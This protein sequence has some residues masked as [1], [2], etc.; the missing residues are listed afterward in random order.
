ME[1]SRYLG[2]GDKHLGFATLLIS[3]SDSTVSE[4]W[5]MKQCWVQYCTYC[6]K[7]FKKCKV[8][9]LVV[10]VQLGA[11][12][13]DIR[14]VTIW[15]NHSSTQY[16]DIAH[17]TVKGAPVSLDEE[18]VQAVFVPT[19]QKRG[20]A[21]IAA[22][23]LSSA[24]SAAKVPQQLGSR[25]RKRPI[26]SDFQTRICLFRYRYP[27]AGLI[28]PDPD[29]CRFCWRAGSAFLV[30]GS[31]LRIR[32]RLHHYCKKAFCRPCTVCVPLRITIFRV[33]TGS[34]PENIS[35]YRLTYMFSLL[36]QLSARICTCHVR[37]NYALEVKKDQ[38]FLFRNTE[39]SVVY[40][41]HLLPR[42]RTTDL[43]ILLLISILRFSSMPF[44]M[45]ANNKY[46]F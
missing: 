13:Q 4:G 7:K 40:P 43:W 33:V 36:F 10:L 35:F 20:A 29:Q 12:V 34:W 25:M 5:Q 8:F 17:A 45:P 3:F 22:R 26:I 46:F 24:M 28:L 37:N 11:D 30:S 38:V 14:R 21:V 27:L 16:P 9:N 6:G 42:I 31:T 2:S 44:K 18:W 1:K 32:S 19:V 15:G 39:I 23:K 41:W